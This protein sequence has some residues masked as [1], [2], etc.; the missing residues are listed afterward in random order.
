MGTVILTL[1]FL[2]YSSGELNMYKV[3]CMPKHQLNDY[4]LCAFCTRSV[5]AQETQVSPWHSSS[6]GDTQISEVYGS[7]GAQGP[8]F[9]TGTAAS[10]HP[11]ITSSD[12]PFGT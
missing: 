6:H 12:K 11:S 9:T 2:E 5:P 10:V 3:N 7:V 1:L 8:V 4:R